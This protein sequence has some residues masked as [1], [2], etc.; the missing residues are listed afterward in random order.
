[1]NIS[2]IS[3][4]TSPSFSAVTKISAP[5]S[6]LSKKDKEYFE[7]LGKQYKTD[8]DTIEIT[9]SELSPSANH[10][11]TQCYTVLKTIGEKC[12]GGYTTDTTKMSIP[13]IKNGEIIE[14]N[15]P[16]NYLAKVFSKMLNS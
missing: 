13:F 14:N 8:R 16:K 7:Q 10:P 1:M 12:A 5:E 4:L 15:S 9:I 2:K 11:E 6:L 3:A